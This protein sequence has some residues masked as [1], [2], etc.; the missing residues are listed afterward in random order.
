[1]DEM[2]YCM[3]DNALIINMYHP[4]QKFK[5]FLNLKQREFDTVPT[6]CEKYER[7]ICDAQ[8]AQAMIITI[9]CGRNAITDE[10]I[11]WLQQYKLLKFSTSSLKTILPSK[12][13]STST[14]N[15]K[16]MTFTI[17]KPPKWTYQLSENV[18]YLLACLHSKQPSK[19]TY[20]SMTNNTKFVPLLI[21]YNNTDQKKLLIALET[22]FWDNN[23]GYYIDEPAHALQY[24]MANK[25][26]V[27]YSNDIEPG[28]GYIRHAWISLSGVQLF[29]E[30]YES[31]NRVIRWYPQ[32]WIDRF[33]R[34]TFCEDNGSKLHHEESLSKETKQYILDKLKQGIII[35][36]RK[37][38]FL[39]F[40]SSQLSQQSVWMYYDDKLN[41]VTADN[42][43]AR[44]GKFSYKICGKI[45]SKNGSMFLNNN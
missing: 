26:N 41:G 37:Y 27:D 34:V 39:A 44:M 10:L 5:V 21:Q 8:Y 12:P 42:I 43:R 35:G 1:M 40:G 31:T 45:C 33:L 24:Y 25:Y 30:Y 2:E 6:L 20:S 3:M 22:M 38:E 16:L 32:I 36:N 29:P 17:S 18:R 7:S 14:T 23:N 13:V 4:I 15:Q 11:E 19:L 28:Y 9:K